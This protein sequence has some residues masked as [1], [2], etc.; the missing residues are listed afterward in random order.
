MFNPGR[1]TIVQTPIPLTQGA[2][3]PKNYGS[4]NHK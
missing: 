3:K 2:K 1:R 4:Y